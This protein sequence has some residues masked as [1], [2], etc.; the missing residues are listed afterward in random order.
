MTLHALVVNTPTCKH[1][2][3]KW[4]SKLLKFRGKD[5]GKSKF[6]IEKGVN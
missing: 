5:L 6:E 4:H 3:D 2:Q 1:N